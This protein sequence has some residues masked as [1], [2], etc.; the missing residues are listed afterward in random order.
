MLLP[1]I[2]TSHCSPCT[3]ATQHPY[4]FWCKLWIIVLCSVCAA[5]GASSTPELREFQ[6][7]VYSIGQA[8]WHGIYYQPHPNAFRPVQFWTHERSLP[9]AYMGTLPLQFFHRKPDSDSP[10]GY[11]YQPIA[12][13]QPPMDSHAFLIVFIAD[14]SNSQPHFHLHALDDR[15]SAFP[16]DT[17]RIFNATDRALEGIFGQ[18]PLKLHPGISAPLPLQSF[19]GEETRIGLAWHDE[20]RLQRVFHSK[21]TF[22]PGYR[23]LLFL[24]PMGKGT[25][26]RVRSLRISEHRETLHPP[27]PDLRDHT[28]GGS[29]Q[30]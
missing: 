12:S 8:N 3:L 7:S 27:P 1:L 26:F 29:H 11:T 23:E 21:Y 13:V 20:G 19:W 25:T 2:T 4:G 16:I 10:D 24:L 6:F 15:E 5:S 22:Y 9:H 18:Q 30:R 28:D 17:L 14:S